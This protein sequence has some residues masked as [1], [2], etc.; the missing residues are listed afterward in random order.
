MRYGHQQL[1]EIERMTVEDIV[2]WTE[3]IIDL[4]DAENGSSK[5]RANGED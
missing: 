1:S 3:E 4:I 2:L 5:L